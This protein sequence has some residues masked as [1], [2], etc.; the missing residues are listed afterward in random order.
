M[1]ISKAIKLLESEEQKGKISQAQ[2]E[3]DSY[4]ST[5]LGRYYKIYPVSNPEQMEK[6]QAFIEEAEKTYFS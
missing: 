6:Y 2:A 4:E 3:R 5:H 1:R